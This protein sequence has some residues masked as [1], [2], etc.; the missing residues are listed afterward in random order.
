MNKGL[1]LPV[2]ALSVFAFFVSDNI[3]AQNAKHMSDT[4]EQVSLS[5]TVNI[6]S[7]DAKTLSTLKGIGPKKAQALVKYREENGNFTSIHDLMKVK[8]FSQKFIE[9]LTKN[10]PNRMVFLPAS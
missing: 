8:G 2:M 6:N 10:N 4:S 7:A 1:L 5:K 3:F 9:R